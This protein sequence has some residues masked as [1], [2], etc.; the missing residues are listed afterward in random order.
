MS[1]VSMCLQLW[2]GNGEGSFIQYRLIEWIV[3]MIKQFTWCWDLFEFDQSIDFYPVF[4]YYY[5]KNVKTLH[6]FDCYIF[7]NIE[8]KLLNLKIINSDW[9]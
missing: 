5:Q 6:H 3:N 9:N 7:T 8:N 4:F 2:K 1:L